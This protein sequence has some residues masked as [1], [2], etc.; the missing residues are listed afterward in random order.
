MENLL[1]DRKVELADIETVKNYV[2]GLRNLLEDNQLTERKYFIKNFVREER[3]T[4]SD[5]TVSYSPPLLSGMMSKE[6]WLV[7]SIV[8]DGGR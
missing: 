5:V 3:V 4:S 1:S 2:E 8:H 6:T 7:P